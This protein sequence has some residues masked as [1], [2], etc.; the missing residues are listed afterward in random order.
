MIGFRQNESDEEEKS[1]P[2]YFFRLDPE[3]NGVNKSTI[4]FH[5]CK[6][7]SQYKVGLIGLGEISSYFIGG[8]L[9]NP[10]TKLLA[11]CRKQKKPE[12]NEKYKD[13]RYYTEWKKLV[14]DPEI[15]CVIIATPPSSHPEITA[16]AL[17]LKKKVI[18]EKPFS[19]VFEDALKC[20]DL[21][22]KIIPIFI[23]HIMRLLILYLYKL[24]IKSP[25]C[26][27]TVRRFL[28]LNLLLKRMFEIIM[29]L[30]LG[31][32]IPK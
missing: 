28:L 29:V 14:D 6:T 22:K 8:V 3:F 32:L 7:M 19:V 1:R 16:Y 31:Y 25:S 21:A 18:V 15:N 27:Q 13:Y 11:V 17:S 9:L 23:L 24:E 2:H 26:L 20:V 4:F 12:D 5:F 30:I 10:R